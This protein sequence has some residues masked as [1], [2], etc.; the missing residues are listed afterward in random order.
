MAKYISRDVRDQIYKL[1]VRL[2]LDY[3]DI[4]YHKRDPEFTH[5]MTRKDW[6]EFNIQQLWLSVEHVWA[7]NFD[8]LYQELDWESLLP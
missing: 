5:E 3:G 4:T 2:Q 6:K 1:Y 7:T 8:R